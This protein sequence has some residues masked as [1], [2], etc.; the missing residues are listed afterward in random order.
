VAGRVIHQ[1]GPPFHWAVAGEVVGD[2]SNDLT[3]LVADPNVSMHEA[4]AFACQLEAGRREAP[5]TAPTKTPSATFK[6]GPVPETP[7]AA[8]P[9]GRFAHEPRD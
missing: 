9:E 6:Q 1:V 3:A 5:R 8:Q 2:N 4:K 7:P